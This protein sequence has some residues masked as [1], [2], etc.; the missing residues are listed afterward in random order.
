[1]EILA[2]G[3][4][5]TVPA[6]HTSGCDS[7]EIY[8]LRL[9]VAVGKGRSVADENKSSAWQHCVPNRKTCLGCGDSGTQSEGAMGNNKG[10]H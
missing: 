3:Q 7:R 4:K 10:D 9:N 2:C 1:M 8:T 6:S 5:K